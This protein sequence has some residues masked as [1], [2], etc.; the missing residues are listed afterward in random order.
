M[1]FYLFSCAWLCREEGGLFRLDRGWCILTVKESA[2][3]FFVDFIQGRVGWRVKGMVGGRDMEA[4]GGQY[5][6]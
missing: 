5:G 3:S 6:G 4:T 1:S 2:G